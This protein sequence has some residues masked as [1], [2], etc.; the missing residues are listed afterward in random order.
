MNAV[1]PAPP[2]ANAL[3]V[4]RD[5]KRVKTGQYNRWL[6]EAAI[7]YRQGFGCVMP[8]PAKTPLWVGIEAAI[9]RR[10][11]LDNCI[12]PLL[13]SMQKAGV[14]LDDRWVDSISVE[15]VTAGNLAGDVPAGWCRV[16]VAA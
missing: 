3:F 7:M 16:T 13:D 4:V 5:G 10:R 14:I 6:R 15:R 2:S 11:D 8:M 9:D 12:K 1:L